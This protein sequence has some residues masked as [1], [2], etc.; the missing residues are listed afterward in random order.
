ML[1]HPALID[2][3]DLRGKTG[4]IRGFER[5]YELRRL[6]SAPVRS[7]IS[8]IHPKLYDLLAIKEEAFDDD[9]DDEDELA[10]HAA[11]SSF[12]EL[13][14]AADMARATATASTHAGN[15]QAGFGAGFY[16]YGGNANTTTS[17]ASLAS[18]DGIPPFAPPPPSIQEED[19]LD[20]LNNSF[21][22][23]QGQGQGQTG[24]LDQRALNRLRKSPS[25]RQLSVGR[26]YRSIAAA[27]CCATISAES[28]NSDGVYLFDDGAALYVK[29]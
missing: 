27:P 16:M 25:A 6:R 10:K 3:R 2:N 14:D 13:D 19:Y 4:L 12:I 26:A 24:E 5:A 22:A 28:L 8:A 23:G 20:N 15:A 1:K 21:T 17:L 7:L 9:Y 11:D 18:G 29:L